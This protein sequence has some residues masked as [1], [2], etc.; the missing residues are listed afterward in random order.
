MY[1]TCIQLTMYEVI[2]NSY[3]WF[4]EGGNDEADCR[5]VLRPSDDTNAIGDISRPLILPSNL[6]GGDVIDAA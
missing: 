2:G 6:I 4:L 1:L 5:E 3:L